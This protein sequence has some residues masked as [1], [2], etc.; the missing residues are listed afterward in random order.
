GGLALTLTGADIAEQMTAIARRRHPLHTVVTAPAERLP[1]DDASQH[2]V[3]CAFGVRNI[4]ARSHALREFHRVLKPKGQLLIME[5]MK[6]QRGAVMGHL[7]DWYTAHM[8]PLIGGMISK[9]REHYAYLPRSMRHF[10]TTEEFTRELQ[11]AG[12]VLT[13]VKTYTLGVT[14]LFV[15]TR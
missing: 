12:F 6:P 1:L 13:T 7:R 14:T 9:K 10:L 5:F 8:L 3:S 4:V 11:E 15:A 2:I